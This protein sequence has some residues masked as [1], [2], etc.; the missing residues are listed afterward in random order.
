[1]IFKIQ[2]WHLRYLNHDRC[3]GYGTRTWYDLFTNLKNA[4]FFVRD[5]II[6]QHTPC[7]HCYF[8]VDAH[9]QDQAR[10]QWESFAARSA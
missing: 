10:N 7:F 9:L 1:M 8:H 3:Q 5:N 2:I 4:V 6:H